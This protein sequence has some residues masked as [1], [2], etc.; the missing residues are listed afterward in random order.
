[1]QSKIS[2]ALPG[3]EACSVELL[4]SNLENSSIVEYLVSDLEDSEVF[5]AP[6]EAPIGD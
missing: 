1:M 4:G 3:A 2:T 5:E 6:T